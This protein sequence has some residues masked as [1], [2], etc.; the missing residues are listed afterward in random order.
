MHLS[1]REGSCMSGSA[2]DLGAAHSRRVTGVTMV[3]FSENARSKTDFERFSRTD[4]TSYK[5]N[6]AW[7]IFISVAGMILTSSLVFFH[8]F[9]VRLWDLPTYS[10]THPWILRGLLLFYFRS[11]QICWGVVV[12]IFQQNATV[13]ETLSD[14]IHVA[15]ISFFVFR[16]CSLLNICRLFV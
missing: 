7:N 8:S 15:D 13:L 5:K 14:K 6:N 10:L 16:S 12:E 9:V 11:F 1:V 2:S 3:S 4:L